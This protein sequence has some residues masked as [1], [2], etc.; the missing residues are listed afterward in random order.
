[1]DLQNAHSQQIP[2][3]IEVSLDRG[4]GGMIGLGKNI[5]P[6]VHID[7]GKLSCCIFTVA[8]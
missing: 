4:Q 2:V 8:C 3:L 7:D 6:N 5:W 1:M